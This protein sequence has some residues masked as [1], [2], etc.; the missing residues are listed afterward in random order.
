[1]KKYYNFITENLS[2]NQQKY[3]DMIV[4][5]LKNHADF[6]LYE[7]AEEFDVQKHDSGSK[8]ITGKLYLIP[9]NKA[10]RF[11]FDKDQLISI[12][13]WENFEFTF[14]SITNKPT[15]TMLINGSIINIL[16]DILDFIN[17]DFELSE[18]LKE[19]S[20]KKSVDED[21]ELKSMTVSKNVFDLDIDIFESIKIYT[22]QVAYKVSNSLV[23]S[24]AAGLGKTS[25]V[26]NTLSDMRV[27]Y[28]PIAGD[29]TTSGLFEI[30]FLNR[31]KLIVFD[32]IDSVFDEKASINLLKA[33]L[34]TKPKRKVSR[35][36]K[37]H[38]DSFTMN[39]KQ[40]QE[41]YEETGKLPKQFEFTGRIIFITNV[42]GDK[43]DDAL[44]SRSLYV[45]VNPKLPEI[46][47]RIK[48]IMPKIQPNVPINK[49]EEVVDFMIM[50]SE[51]YE[52]R[53]AINLRTFVHCLNIRMSNEFNMTISGENI[54]A[55]QMLIKAYLV[56]K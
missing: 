46:I 21:V 38:F 31:D 41:K 42:A 17:G 44:I 7:Y 19:D 32:D 1:M 18:K 30:L 45:D 22:A 37:T 16:H 26:E 27:D 29:I 20:I 34:D 40:I 10:V 5:Y 13:M 25:D 56:K 52:I 3:V 50:L 54:Q 8:H 36:L 47:T 12:D 6:D 35:I 39:D 14:K 49:K 9:N 28:V 43:L 53:F 11:N 24:G 23:V 15:Y 48:T 2:R 55:W 51:K 4:N 33:V